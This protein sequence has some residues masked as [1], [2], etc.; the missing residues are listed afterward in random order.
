MEMKEL[1]INGEEIM[2]RLARLQLDMKFVR[3]HIEDVVLTEDD[4]ESIEEA[5]RD[6]K[7]GKTRRL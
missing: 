1:T 6:L 2:S 3:E 4:L 5:K 7:E